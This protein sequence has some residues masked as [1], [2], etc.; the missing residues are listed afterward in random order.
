MLEFQ[1]A[2]RAYL[3]KIKALSTDQHDKV[4]FVGLTAKE[5]VWYADY[6][7]E[8]FNGQADRTGTSQEK[9]LALLDRHEK[10]RQELVAD[11]DPM[12]ADEPLLQ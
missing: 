2:A 8:S 1:P 5:S 11:Q 7:Q 10:A 3:S 9:Y 6:L 4:V 12:R